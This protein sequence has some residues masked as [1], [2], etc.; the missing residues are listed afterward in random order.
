MAPHPFRRLHRHWLD[1][2]A[3]ADRLGAD[4]SLVEIHRLYQCHDLLLAHKTSLFDHLT[5]CWRTLYRAKFEVHLYELT[6]TYFESNPPADPA[7]KAL[8]DLT[9]HKRP[10]KRD[11]LHQAIGAAKKQAG[12]DARHVKVQVQLDCH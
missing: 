7:D 10:L 3:L 5:K 11:E 6:S 8:A 12:R 4:F 9:T 1:H 2:S